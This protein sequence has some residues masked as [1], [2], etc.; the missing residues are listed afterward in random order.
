VVNHS[1]K[2]LRTSNHCRTE[3]D[4]IVVEDDPKNGICLG[5]GHTKTEALFKATL[6]LQHEM[7]TICELLRNQN[8][9]H[10]EPK[11]KEHKPAKT[12]I[13]SLSTKIRRFSLWAKALN[14]GSKIT[15]KEHDD[16]IAQIEWITNR[17]NNWPES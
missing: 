2:R 7:N 12:G 8:N 3:E 11:Q 13:R 10:V 1:R 15:Q 16:L 17:L 5:S 6:S 9:A 4:W 14:P